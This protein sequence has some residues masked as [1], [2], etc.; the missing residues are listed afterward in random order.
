LIEIDPESDPE[1]DFR[2]RISDFR[3]GSGIGIGLWIGSRSGLSPA[4]SMMA[5][6]SRVSRGVL[7]LRATLAALAP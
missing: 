6:C 7:A 3:S 4:I 5:A 1:S 2:D